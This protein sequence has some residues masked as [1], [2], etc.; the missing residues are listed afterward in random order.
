MFIR[1]SDGTGWEGHISYKW[2]VVREKHLRLIPMGD[3]MPSIEEVYQSYG[4]CQAL[5]VPKQL[6][7]TDNFDCIYRFL[8]GYSVEELMEESES[9]KTRYKKYIHEPQEW[10]SQMVMSMDW[11]MFCFAYYAFL[12]ADNDFE[13]KVWDV[14]K[15][16]FLTLKKTP[17]ILTSL[18]KINNIKSDE[19]ECSL[20]WE[21]IYDGLQT[22]IF[23][24]LTAAT[25]HTA[26]VSMCNVSDVFTDERYQYL[27]NRCSKFFGEIA[28]RRIDN[29]HNKQYTV[30][31]L[32]NYNIE[33]LFFYQD[34]FET[35]DNNEV[36]KQYVNNSVFNLLHTKGDKIVIAED[37]MSADK[38]YKTALKYAQ[39][40]DDR[41][42]IL[43]KRN[44]IA[45]SVAVAKAEYEENL[46]E[47]EKKREEEQEEIRRRNKTS[48]IVGGILLALFLGSIVL[49]ILFGILTFFDVFNPFSKIVFVVS[50]SIVILFLIMLSKFK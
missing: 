2:S 44:I 25:C 20:F 13:S 10:T 49:A 38:V 4:V 14:L 42:L 32:V 33:S 11:K 29:I 16:I 19:E 37:F 46:R 35:L 12:G 27:K 40:D 9:D 7:D 21:T 1:N 43:N 34:Y 24:L 15:Y 31:E 39:T 45:P 22:K 23:K 41:A 36:I 47:Y 26:F 50:L 30:S 6:L 18:L 3:S 17:E 5:E 8:Y 48:D 28:K